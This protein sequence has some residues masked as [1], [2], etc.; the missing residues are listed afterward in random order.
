LG[1]MVVEPGRVVTAL[2]PL[3][4]DPSEEVCREAVAALG[5]FGDENSV[6]QA[7]G[8]K[9]PGVRWW[10]AL[11][12]QGMKPGQ[13]N[14]RALQELQSGLMFRVRLA[15]AL[16]LDQ[17]TDQRATRW[18]SQLLESREAEVR[19]AAYVAILTLRPK[20]PS[21]AAN[22]VTG[23]EKKEVEEQVRA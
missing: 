18:L 3:L 15:P 20:S 22:L 21:L 17:S 4:S 14:P 12:L 7:L 5:Q 13:P 6:K 10:A 1:D 11:I 19:H 16:Y 9:V 2:V 23:L 8:A